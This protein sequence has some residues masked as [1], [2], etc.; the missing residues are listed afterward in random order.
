MVFTIC[1]SFKFAIQ[2][3]YSKSRAEKAVVAMAFRL[4]IYYLIIDAIKYTF[5]T[6]SNHIKN[7]YEDINQFK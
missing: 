6:N 4:L 5:H 7:I 3:P 2:T 1:A